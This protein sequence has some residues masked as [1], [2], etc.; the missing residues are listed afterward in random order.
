MVTAKNIRIHAWS[1]ERY[2]VVEKGRRGDCGEELE[3]VGEELETVSEELETVGE[4]LETVGE[5]LETVSCRR[6]MLLWYHKGDLLRKRGKEGKLMEKGGDERSN[7][8]TKG[9][10]TQKGNKEAAG[11]Q[12]TWCHV[13]VR[14]PCIWWLRSRRVDQYI[15]MG[16]NRVLHTK[17]KE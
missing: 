7:G 14:W 2:V 5:E 12:Q 1:A 13:V 11:M 17:N 8:W 9:R 10:R 15:W 16:N 6:V 3:T 4:E